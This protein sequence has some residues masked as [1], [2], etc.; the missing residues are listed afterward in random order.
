SNGS[1]LFAGGAAFATGSQSQIEA[2]TLIRSIDGGSTWGDNSLDGGGTQLHVDHHAIAFTSAGDKVYVGNDGGVWSS[3]DALNPAVVA[4]SQHWADLNA[5][6]NLTQFYPGNSI[7]P[8]SDQVIF[9]GTQDNGTE[10]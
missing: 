10:Q 5:T 2:P 6:L 3:T 7:H 9:G 4:G 1:V 8:A